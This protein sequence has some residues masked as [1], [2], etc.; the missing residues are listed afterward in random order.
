MMMIDVIPQEFFDEVPVGPAVTL[1]GE[2]LGALDEAPAGPWLAQLIDG[3][4][5]RSLTAFELPTYVRQCARMQAWSASCLDTAVAELAS[6]RDPDVAADAEVSLALR[7]PLQ[8]AQRRIHRALRLRSLLP[9]FKRAFH[10]GDLSEYDVSQLVDATS[11]TDDPEVLARVQESTLGNLRGQAGKELRRYARRL[12]DRLD[13]GAANRRARKA[14][15][16]ADVTLQP[17]EDGMA[18]IV[19]NQ[20]V[21]DAM[22]VK[23]ALDAKAITAKQA[24]DTRPI[25]VLR[26][27]A[28]TALCADALTG[29]GS[30]GVAPRSGGRPIEI[31]VVV[32]LRTALGL[33]DLPGEVPAAGL[34]PRDD[35]ARMI[36]DDQARLRMLVVDDGDGPGRGRVVYRG[37][38][39]YRPTA[40]QI[41]YVRAAYPTSLGPASEVRAER[42]DVDHFKEWPDGATIETNLGPFDRPWH[43]RKTRGSLSVTV[44]D[45]GAVIVTTVLGQSRT[46]TP[47][48]YSAHL[49]PRPDTGESSMGPEPAPF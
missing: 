6:R 41:A 34:V 16:D 46:V 5:V 8:L 44:D 28:L 27:Q 31:N 39:G 9:A 11:C 26:S 29:A 48:D 33:E 13:P 35:I 49:D 40:E 19:T 42:C 1:D 18:S 30:S 10:R 3:V 7:E 12:L 38:D 21:E 45:S 22:I 17:G 36:A 23:A 15:A 4:D 47:Y 25:G 24:G 2:L 20:P 37:H 43:N 32:G 14:R